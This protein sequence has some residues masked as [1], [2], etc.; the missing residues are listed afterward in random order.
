KKTLLP[1]DLGDLP[2]PEGKIIENYLCVPG[3]ELLGEREWK[4]EVIYAVKQLKPSFIADYV[5]LGG[6]NVHRFTAL[7]KGI[8]RGQN[9]N[10]FFG[11]ARWSQKKEHSRQSKWCVRS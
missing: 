10:A 3:L 7:P 5:V 2:Y 4:R 9:E 1:L 8:A 6:G 11:G